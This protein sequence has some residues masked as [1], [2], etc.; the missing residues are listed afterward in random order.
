[1]GPVGAKS[2]VLT[3]PPDSPLRDRR[4]RKE[5]NK[6]ER[7]LVFAGLQRWGPLVV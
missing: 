2:K 7:L 4:G 5:N 1:M 3:G 6:I